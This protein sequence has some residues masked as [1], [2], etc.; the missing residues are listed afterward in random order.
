[1]K[2]HGQKILEE[3]SKKREKNIRPKKEFYEGQKN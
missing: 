3:I 1:M 2:K